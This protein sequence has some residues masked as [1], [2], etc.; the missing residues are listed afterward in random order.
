M[1]SPDSESDFE[2]LGRKSSF[3]DEPDDRYEYNIFVIALDNNIQ[4]QVKLLK[5][6]N[7][8]VIK[9]MTLGTIIHFVGNL[10]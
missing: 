1:Q 4:G 2:D 10:T 5:T 3:E 6:L 9:M 7:R 8:L